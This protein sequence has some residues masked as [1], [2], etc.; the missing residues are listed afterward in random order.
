MVF[1][2][3][4]EQSDDFIA[5]TETMPDNFFGKAVARF[6]VTTA[7]LP[8]RSQSDPQKVGILFM[9][10]AAPVTFINIGTNRV[11]AANQ[12]AYQRF[13]LGVDF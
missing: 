7:C 13:A 12:L 1:D 6:E 2:G 10:N 5:Y 3:G 4:N 9:F 8:C 11:G